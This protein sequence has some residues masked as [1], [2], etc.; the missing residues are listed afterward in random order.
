MDKNPPIYAVNSVRTE[1]AARFLVIQEL[2]G[3]E[4]SPVTPVSEWSYV[5]VGILW[6]GMWT[7]CSLT[8]CRWTGE[9][10]RP[11]TLPMEWARGVCS[12]S[13]N[14]IAWNQNMSPAAREASRVRTFLL[15]SSLRLLAVA[16]IKCHSLSH[17]SCSSKGLMTHK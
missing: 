17:L 1:L 2:G 6:C 11:S 16:K 10:G 8:K 14:T 3:G 9:Q 13:P 15:Q 12:A 4:P 5:I 7:L